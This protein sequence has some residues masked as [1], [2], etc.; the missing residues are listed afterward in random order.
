MLAKSRRISSLMSAR[1]AALSGVFRSLGSRSLGTTR[2]FSLAA[3]RYCPKNHEMRA[4]WL[5]A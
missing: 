3:R 4:V 5:R 1:M 2:P